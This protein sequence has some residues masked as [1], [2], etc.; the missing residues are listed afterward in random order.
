[1]SIVTEYHELT[2]GIKD[3]PLHPKVWLKR[4]AFFLKAEYPVLSCADAYKAYLLADS[5]FKT[6]EEYRCNLEET[7]L[8]SLRN[9]A[10]FALAKSLIELDDPTYAGDCLDEIEGEEGEETPA[11]ELLETAV[12][13]KWDEIERTDKRPSFKHIEYPW[14]AIKHQTRGDDVLTR[15]RRELARYG[16]E[17][18]QSTVSRDP[19]VLGVFAK[20]DFVAGSIIA[21]RLDTEIV[22]VKEVSADKD[23]TTFIQ[24]ILRDN[25]QKALVSEHFH[26]LDHKV[27]STLTGNYNSRETFSFEDH[28][29][30]IF[31]ILAPRFH[32]YEEGFDYWVILTALSR[33]RN[34]RFWHNGWEGV[35]DIFSF[36]NHSCSWNTHWDLPRLPN[37]MR[38]S[39]RKKISQGEELFVSYLGDGDSKMSVSKR[40]QMLTGWFNGDCMCSKCKREAEALDRNKRSRDSDD[41]EGGKKKARK[42]IK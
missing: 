20:R 35:Q 11:K 22:E 38:L 5:D 26:L 24:A 12:N 19:R 16:L 25:V 30:D 36:I 13:S 41:Q 10:R 21:E 1:M 9:E 6:K 8:K 7:V 23:M 42:S 3:R 39:A 28:I 33:I 15:P 31:E 4:A 32:V 17:L 40:R 29:V 34:N 27:I 2:Q 18:K 14:M 37:Q